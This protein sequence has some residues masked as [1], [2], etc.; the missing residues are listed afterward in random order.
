M[1]IVFRTVAVYVFL[2]AVLRALGKRE[3]S[4]MS[5]FELVLLVTMGDLVQQ[6]VTQED[7]SLTGAFLAVGTIALLTLALSF[8]QYR[9]RAT[10]PALDGIPVV[11]VHEG[12]IL[13]E[14]A[15]LERVTE[16]E[17]ITAAR[18]KGIARLDDI[19]LGVL[20]PEG[21]FSFITTQAAPTP[22]AD[23]ER[24]AR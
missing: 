10:R 7:M 20:E 3:L 1:E 11:V 23:E 18:Q 5:S 21:K 16:E 6:G 19:L 2:Y 9:W 12:R 13:T 8:V 15:H 17:I 22:D 14:R 4:E 24:I